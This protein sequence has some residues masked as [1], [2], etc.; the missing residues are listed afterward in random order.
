M[1]S[2][3]LD[4]CSS[5]E[6]LIKKTKPD[7]VLGK[8][9]LLEQAVGSK[10]ALELAICPSNIL[11]LVCKLQFANELQREADAIIRKKEISLIG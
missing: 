11:C 6:F 4:L 2:L 7:F 9:L 3:N 5:A 1:F 10:A 8:I